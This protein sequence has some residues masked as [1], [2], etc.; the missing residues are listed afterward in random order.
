MAK[1]TIDMLF[2]VLDFIDPPLVLLLSEIRI[3][4]EC[5][6]KWCSLLPLDRVVGR[7]KTWGRGGG[8]KDMD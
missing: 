2:C 1:N 4:Y 8:I 6:P 3:V 5:F 7:K